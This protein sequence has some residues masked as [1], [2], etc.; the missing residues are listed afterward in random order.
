MT[1]LIHIPKL[2]ISQGT[3]MSKCQL[4]SWIQSS[5]IQSSCH[6]TKK[7]LL[8]KHIYL[9]QVPEG[10]STDTNKKKIQPKTKHFRDHYKA[11]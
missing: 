6:R 11:T 5:W 4:D 7:H 9:H 8:L 1:G 3:S 2:D 10:I